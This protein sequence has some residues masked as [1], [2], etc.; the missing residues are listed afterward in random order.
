LSTSTFTFT[1]TSSV[2]TN[3]HGHLT[4]SQELITGTG[5]TLVPAPTG[6]ANASS[7]GHTNTTVA[8]VGGAVGGLIILI[9]GFLLC[10]FLRRRSRNQALY[11]NS[12]PDSPLRDAERTMPSEPNVPVFSMVTPHASAV[13]SIAV[14]SPA[15]SQVSSPRPSQSSHLTVHKK[16]V[17]SFTEQDLAGLATPATQAKP[18]SYTLDVDPPTSMVFDSNTFAQSL[19][20]DPAWAAVLE[21]PSASANPFEDPV[22]PFADP[23]PKTR[24]SEMPEIPKHLRMSTTSSTLSR[25]EEPN[26]S[27]TS[28]VYHDGFAL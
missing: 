1:S 10:L 13:P 8:A 16:P 23:A 3:F 25:N 20:K 28:T 4:T 15:M 24:L 5:V 22:N 17:P 21:A 18:A 6:T 27:P 7:S 11:L 2:V 26:L 19:G 14:A 9:A 12:R